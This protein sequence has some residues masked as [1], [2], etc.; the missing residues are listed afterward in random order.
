MALPVR[1]SRH[2]ALDEQ[3]LGEVVKTLLFNLAGLWNL[4][5]FVLVAGT[6]GFF[7][8]WVFLRKI[9]RAKRISGAHMKRMLREASERESEAK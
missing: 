5:L 6:L 7:F 4:I 3:S 1:S 8:Y 9:L 2:W